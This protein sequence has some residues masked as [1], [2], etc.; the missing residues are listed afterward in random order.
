MHDD[1]LG[2]NGVDAMTERY[3]KAFEEWLRRYQVNPLEFADYAS[4]MGL[5]EPKSYGQAAAAY[6]AHLLEATSSEPAP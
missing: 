2:T 3:A 4:R 1:G 6:F 5:A